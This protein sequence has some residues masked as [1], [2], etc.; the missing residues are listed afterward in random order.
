MDGS[1]WFAKWLCVPKEEVRQKVLSE[2]YRSS[3]PFILMEWKYIKTWSST[4]GDIGQNGWLL[5]LYPSVSWRQQVKAE[6]LRVFELLQPFLILE[7]KWEK[8]FI[9]F[10]TV[11]LR[12]PN[13]NYAMWV[14][15][16][17]LTKMVYFIPFC[18]GLSIE[19]FAKKYIHEV[20]KLHSVPNELALY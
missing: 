1:L 14:I 9:D 2:A 8:G 3:I 20:E 12:S 13:D 10:V 6:H 15:V 7:W 17:H 4:F 18:M 11:L 16:D 5:D 19:A